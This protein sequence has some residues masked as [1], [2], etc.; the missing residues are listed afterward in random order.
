MLELLPREREYLLAIRALST[1]Q[2]DK[3]VFVGMTESD[4]VWYAKY[5]AESFQGNV[6]RNDDQQTRYLS[7]HEQHE[8]ARRTI[9][10]SESLMPS[11]PTLALQ[12]L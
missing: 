7:L 6:A 8:E 4:S 5:L 1:N 2:D 9:L 3:L 11:H 12:S 10:A